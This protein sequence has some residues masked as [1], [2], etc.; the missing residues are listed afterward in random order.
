[1]LILGF[2]RL[3]PRPYRGAGRAADHPQY[4]A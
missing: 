1:V 2:T 4:H 3:M